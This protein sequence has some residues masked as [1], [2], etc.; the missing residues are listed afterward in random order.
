MGYRMYSTVPNPAY[1]ENLTIFFRCG[2]SIRTESKESNVVRQKRNPQQYAYYAYNA[3][4]TTPGGN[5]Y[6]Y[7]YYGNYDYGVPVT[8]PET[9]TTTTTTTSP[10]TKLT[11]TKKA[12]TT[13][14]RTI[15][16]IKTTTIKTTTT[17]TT[18]TKKPIITAA[19]KAVKMITATIE[20]VT[21]TVAKDFCRRQSVT[22]GDYASKLGFTLLHNSSSESAKMADAELY[23][24]KMIHAEM[25]GAEIAQR[26]TD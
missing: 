4:S 17:K 22:V 19:A 6:Y 11:T 1:L 25:A 14:K 8:E 5:Y 15:T 2:Q 24:T 16:T 26:R 13:P 3:E 21:T 18:T 23:G 7:D 20:A 9:T 12:T 10:K